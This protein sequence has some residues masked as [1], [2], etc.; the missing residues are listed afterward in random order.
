MG[1][2]N[3]DREEILEV[4]MNRHERR[5]VE[6]LERKQHPINAPMTS[7]GNDDLDRLFGGKDNL[8]LTE[9][10]ISELIRD[11]GMKESDVR[12]LA[13]AGALYCPPRNSFIFP[14]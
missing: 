5:K 2:Y 6:K 10:L 13:A 3:R 11:K 12:E 4:G 1:E 14:S 8:P 7:V 9:D